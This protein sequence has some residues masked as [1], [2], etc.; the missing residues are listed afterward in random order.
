MSHNYKLIL[1][2]TLYTVLAMVLVSLDVTYG[3][4]Q[5]IFGNLVGPGDYGTGISLKSKGFYL[6]ILVFALL[7]ALP[8][9]MCKGSI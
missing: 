2:S 9:L 7:I 8:M 5:S 6:H 4:T 1:F 3:V